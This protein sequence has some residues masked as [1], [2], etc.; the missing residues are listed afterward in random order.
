MWIEVVELGLDL[1]VLCFLPVG[2]KNCFT[3]SLP[4]LKQ[5]QGK[6]NK[7][8]KK[9][10]LLRLGSREKKKEE[11]SILDVIREIRT[12]HSEFG[13]EE[14]AMTNTCGGGCPG[15]HLI[16]PWCTLSSERPCTWS[17]GGATS[18]HL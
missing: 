16:F 8:K 9:Q 5:N 7:K 11:E 18:A 6:L 3:M 1:L 17:T 2:L 12:Y 10:W 14:V 13:G 15:Q 4:D